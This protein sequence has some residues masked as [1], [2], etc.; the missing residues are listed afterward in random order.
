MPDPVTSGR[1]R[2]DDQTH[3]SEQPNPALVRRRK[4]T[5]GLGGLLN[6]ASFYFKSPSEH[7]RHGKP[8]AGHWEKN[9]QNPVGRVVGWHDCRAD[10]DDQPSNHC[11]TER[12]TID[13]PLFQFTEE[14]TH[15]DPRRERR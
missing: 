4:N 12:D 8:E 10:L 2:A 3:G 6:Y 9:R 15:R 11:V 5:G 1:E 14:G 7:E 13:L